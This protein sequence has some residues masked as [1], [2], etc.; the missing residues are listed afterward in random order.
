MAKLKVSEL[1]RTANI[2]GTDLVYV[3]QGVNSRA[4]TVANLFASVVQAGPPGP[5]GPTGP[6]GPQGDQGLPGQEGPQGD[7][8]VEF[9][10]FANLES[11]TYVFGGAGFPDTEN[12]VNPSLYV[13]RGF[14]YAFINSSASFDRLTIRDSANGNV[15]TR[16]VDD[17]G[18][19]F[20]VQQVN[21][22]VP[23]NAPDTLYYQ[24]NVYPSMGNVIYVR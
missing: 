4:S 1:T 11:N 18:N 16:G 17:S 2:T 12:L 19:I 23:M 24:S 3:V 21:F 10:L 5:P 22:N 14:T 9:S 8:T 6:S 7:I 13:Y 20:S 15:Y